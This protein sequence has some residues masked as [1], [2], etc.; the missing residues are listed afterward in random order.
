MHSPNPEQA[1]GRAQ[2]IAVIYSPFAN[3]E[4]PYTARALDPPPSPLM[5]CLWL[6]K[7]N[8]RGARTATP[9]RA[10]AGGLGPEL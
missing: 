4:R 6:W 2:H 7:E 9:A 3:L 5:S 1:G 8:G 10:T